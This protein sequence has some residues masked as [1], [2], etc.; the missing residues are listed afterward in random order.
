MDVDS[1][2]RLSPRP[3]PEIRQGKLGSAHALSG[4]TSGLNGPSYGA[5][6]GFIKPLMTGS[7]RG[8]HASAH[9][10]LA[11]NRAGTAERRREAEK[12]LSL[13][14]DESKGN[15][16]KHKESLT[17]QHAALRTTGLRYHF[18]SHFSLSKF[19]ES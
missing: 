16:K 17:V 14:V 15:M 9:T 18:Q 4:A 5:A 10:S 11:R 3:A 2:E 1:L 12:A 19:R 7:P 13:A 8:G 6:C